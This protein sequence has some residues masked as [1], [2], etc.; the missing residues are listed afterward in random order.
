MDFNLTWA[1]GVSDLMGWSHGEVFFA[2]GQIKDGDADG[3]RRAF[4]SE[5]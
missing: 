1:L 3:W 2:A 5:A 4:Y